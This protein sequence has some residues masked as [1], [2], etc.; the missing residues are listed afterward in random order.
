[1][2]GAQRNPAHRLS[3][4][5][6][7]H[8]HPLV[9]VRS[10]VV[11]AALCLAM[12][13]LYV[14]ALLLPLSLAFGE[15]ITAQRRD[16]A[17]PTHTLLSTHGVPLS[18][19]K[20]R[21]RHEQ[22]LDAELLDIVLVAS[23]D[24][25]F[26]AMNR[27]T[28]QTLWS[29]GGTA[30]ST[31]QSGASIVPSTLG[32]LVR[33]VHPEFDPDL[34]DELHQETYIIEP[35][36]GDIYVMATPDSPLLRF[37]FS[38][39][40]LVDIS[41]FSFPDREDRRVFVGRKETSLVLLELE[42]GRIKATLNSECP[43]DP[44]EDFQDDPDYVD[45]DELEGSKPKPK[46]PTE[47][48]IGRTD[49]HISI[50]TR[51]KPGLPPPPAQN[52][53]FSAYG[54][55]NQDNIDQSNYH[56]TPDNAYIQGLPNGN[57]MSFKA[58][59]AAPLLWMRQFSSPV[60]AVFDVL[61]KPSPHAHGSHTF[62]LLQPRPGL[63][64]ILPS[65][66]MDKALENL[67]NSQNAFVGMVEETGSL[68]A[69]SPLRYPLVAFGD[70]HTAPRRFLDPPPLPDDIDDITRIRKQMEREKERERL[71]SNDGC[72]AG[73]SERRCLIGIRPLEG[74][75]GE[76]PESRLRRLLNG[77]PSPFPQLPPAEDDNDTKRAPSR[78]TEPADEL[79]RPEPSTH[80]R[81]WL[82]DAFLLTAFGAFTVWFGLSMMKNFAK[83][84]GSVAIPS[85][86][87]TSKLEPVHIAETGSSEPVEQLP[88]PQLTPGSESLPAV[89]DEPAKPVPTQ[90]PETDN[91]EGERSEVD[92]TTTPKKKVRRGNRG[93]AGKKKKAAAVVVDEPTVSPSSSLVIES[94]PI[95]TTPSLVVS[96]TILGFGSHGTVVFQGS[97]QGRA[98][99]VKRLLQDF[100]TLAAREVSILQDSDDHPNVIR[101][102]Y[103]EA[104][105]NFL[106]IAL[107]LCPC[108][109]ADIIETPDRE[110]VRPLAIAF[111]PKKAL[112]QLTGGL[113]HLHALKL[114]HRDIKPQNIL[115]SSTGKMLIS[116]FG[117]CKRLD[118]DQTS[119]LPTANGA[120]GAG[121]VG[122]RAP[123]ILRGEVKLDEINDEG[124]IGS[125]RGSGGTVTGGS[126]GSVGSGG[127]VTGKPTRLTK[128]VDIFALGC[129]FYYVLSNGGH[130]FGDR[131]EREM[132]ILKNEKNL[133]A[134]ERFGEEGSEAG[135]LI[136]AMLDPEARERPDTTSCLVHPFF[137]NPGRRLNFLQDASDRFE[138]M[139]RDPK[140]ANL[141][142][143]EKG[144]QKIVG[145]DWHSRLDKIFIENLGK[146]RKYDG[147]SVQDLLRALRNKKHHYQDL[148]ESVRRHLGSM[149]EGYLA[150]FTRRYPHLV[151][152]VH[153][154]IGETSL[155]TESMFRSYYELAEA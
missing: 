130:P 128:S 123:E 139:C 75:D 70:S 138:V 76:G 67:P 150:Y 134:L 45:L 81:K 94:K 3:P 116:D 121:T 60:V 16:L 151:M 86:S 79:R 5:Y 11:G 24:G 26:H 155:R 144:A 47:I 74:G 61:Q 49:Y 78:H 154:V 132:N 92:P 22:Q 95:V 91:E 99:A 18:S 115:V 120:M 1:M 122:W 85:A 110:A 50:Y 103:Q 55:N 148:P 108:S 102:Y 6:H 12:T 100:V 13:P 25:K 145:N 34:A 38:M 29:M 135:H 48:F 106:Y 153:R 104:H 93:G 46:P 127:P 30:A 131:Y 73:S 149:P 52:L 54:P 97:L 136:E 114:V 23:V 36:S 129:L 117:L 111:E 137:W 59:D 21:I 43:W 51:P 66:D 28:G 17:R 32:P 105:S 112:G 71:F 147:K 152:H 10:A 88:T 9:F 62:A 118:V 64:D 107:E 69:M 40:E 27:K 124:S 142:S 146:F 68:F 72:Y 58:A 39:P 80:T 65:M 53:S 119:F 109:L 87:E 4:F 19:P 41:P 143:L 56:R 113:R 77:A 90:A 37:P 84:S 44:F 35:Q 2:A 82:I 33:T 83:G 8:Q 96:E 140:D 7:H 141:L 101:Y 42:T 20:Q 31:T 98:V 15:I 14:A 125:S 89:L 133:E 63:Q 57:I 126:T